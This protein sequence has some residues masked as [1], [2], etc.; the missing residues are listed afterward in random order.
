M[1]NTSDMNLTQELHIIRAHQL[2][3]SSLLDDFKKIVEF[4]RTTKNPA[5]D[6]LDADARN[7]SSGLMDRECNYLLSEIKRLEM[8]RK[9]QDKRLKNVMNLVCS[10]AAIGIAIGFFYNGALNPGL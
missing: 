5:M 3:Y 2:H 7:E 8:S 6:A 1:I 9:M 10:T 4:V